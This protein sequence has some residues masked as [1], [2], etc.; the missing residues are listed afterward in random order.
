MFHGC[1]MDVS[2]MVHGWFMDINHAKNGGFPCMLNGYHSDCGRCFVF[3]VEWWWSVY[4]F[5]RP[6][7]GMGWPQS[8]NGQRMTHAKS[9]GID[10]LVG[11][12]PTPLK[13][14]SSSIGMMKFLI[15]GK[16]KNDP[17]HQPVYLLDY[18]SS[19][20]CPKKKRW[21][22]LVFWMCLRGWSMS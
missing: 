11:G 22:S 15:Y 20:S 5:H 21:F 16:I 7:A 17:N 13:N 12:I 3:S 19:C 4:I 6:P 18:P 1:F 14:M 2:W 8:A 9:V 10:V